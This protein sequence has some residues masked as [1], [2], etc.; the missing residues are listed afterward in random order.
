MLI[1]FVVLVIALVIAMGAI[2]FDDIRWWW[3][4]R[5]H[6]RHIRRPPR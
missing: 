5:R 1:G 3:W 6:K 4:F 2:L